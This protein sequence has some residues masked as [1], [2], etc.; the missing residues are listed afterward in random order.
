MT[1]REN[2]PTRYL[3]LLK[4]ALLPQVGRALSKKKRRLR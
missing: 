3:T 2:R 1:R 4:A